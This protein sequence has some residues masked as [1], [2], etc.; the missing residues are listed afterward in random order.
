MSISTRARR[1]L[2]SIAAA[3]IIVSGV[4]LSAAP[5]SAALAPPAKMAA[6]GDSISQASMTCTALAQCP[7]N[8]WSTGTAS[9]SH[10]SRMRALPGGGALTTYNYSVPGV[11]SSVLRGQA[12]KAI[13]AQV[14][15]VTIEIGAMDACTKTVG[16]MTT[17]ATF[18]NNVTN[19]INAL[20]AKNIQILVASI[21][22]LNKMWELNK[23]NLVARLAWA[24]LG[25]CQSLLDN[26]TSTKAADVQR[27]AA[28]QAR[29]AEFNSVL[30]AAC[31][32]ANKPNAPKLCSWDG[33]AVAAASFTK[34]HISTTDYFHPSTAGQKLIA[35]LTWPA[36]PYK[37]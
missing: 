35:D 11:A 19:A 10:A 3:A 18:K 22:N 30:A 16:T 23:S 26:P 29:V 7:A 27:R 8:S 14:Q 17:T 36:S 34:S 1:A 33:G 5:A 32:A 37:P 9:Y 13:A 6:L 28:V 20:A 12:D 2:A 24:L 4:V 25:T 21:P 15:Y 31:A